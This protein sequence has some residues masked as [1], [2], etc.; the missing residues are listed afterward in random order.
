M[1]YKI[2]QHGR[3]SI[4]VPDNVLFEGGAGETVRLELFKQADV[5]TLLCS[6]TGIF[7][8][9]GVGANVLLFDRKPAHEK[10]WTK[11]FGSTISGPISISL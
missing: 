10:A 11:S 7:C 2:Q 6:P 5:R 1:G 9:Q 8:A 4:V 3:A